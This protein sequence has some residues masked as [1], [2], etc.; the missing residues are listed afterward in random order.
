MLFRLY[1]VGNYSDRRGHW[2]LHWLHSEGEVTICVKMTCDNM[3]C[4]TCRLPIHAR[5][6]PQRWKTFN[7]RY[8][9]TQ[10]PSVDAA[11]LSFQK[12]LHE[13][14]ETGNMLYGRTLQFTKFGYCHSVLSV[15]SSVNNTSVH[16][17]NSSL[18]CSSMLQLFARQVWGR[19]SR[20][21]SWSVGWN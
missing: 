4:L 18:K 1:F 5:Q 8:V 11:T 7:R 6:S 2:Q 15:S 12:G 10:G 21:S 16:D 19:N 13:S 14:I 9:L 20:R 17:K 3:A